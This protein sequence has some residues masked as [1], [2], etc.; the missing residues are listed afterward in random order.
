MTSGVIFSSL[1]LRSSCNGRLQLVAPVCGGSYARRAYATEPPTPPPSSSPAFGFPSDPPP[2][3]TAADAT[4][5]AAVSGSQ[6]DRPPSGGTTTA[7]SHFE[8]HDVDASLLTHPYWEDGSALEDPYH[9]AHW[10]TWIAES[11][12]DGEWWGETSLYIDQ[13]DKK[14]LNRE[15]I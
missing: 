15:F 10:S 6:G 1:S 12:L 8:A 3:S 11:D 14:L 5:D 7:P 13:E 4:G 9:L 2:N